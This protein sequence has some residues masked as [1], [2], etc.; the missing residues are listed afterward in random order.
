MTNA[1]KNE[2]DSYLKAVQNGSMSHEA[3]YE[4]LDLLY[5]DNASQIAVIWSTEDV[6]E[7]DDSFSEEKAFDVLQKVK[8]QHDCNFGITWEHIGQAMDDMVK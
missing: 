2:I 3:F 6:M 4:M 5:F 1:C 8:D 7:L